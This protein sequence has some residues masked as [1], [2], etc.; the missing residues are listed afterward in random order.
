[1]SGKI[2]AKKRRIMFPIGAKLIIIISVLLLAS[3]GAVIM[4]VSMLITQEVQKTAETNNF[5]VNQKAASQAGSSFK[6]IQTAVL[7]YLEMT[8]AVSSELILDHDLDRYFFSHNI[9]AIGI[10]SEIKS[11]FILNQQFF[12]TKN[13]E[14]SEVENYL[15][16]DFPSVENQINFF[17]A[18]PIFQFSLI[19]AVFVRK[20]LES[21]ETVKVLFIPDDLSESFGAGT[22][23]SFLIN[24]SGDLLLHADNNLVLG[25]ANFSSLPIVAIMQQQGD[26]N[27]Q[28]SYNDGETEYFGAY[29]RIAGTNTAVITTISHSLVFEA[30]Q[31]ITRQNIFLTAAVLFIAIIF[32]WL[33]S[34]TI[35]SP[36]KSLAGAVLKIEEGDFSVYLK[37]QT[38]DELGVLTESFD[39]MSRALNIFGRFTNMDIALRS[40]RGEIKP[41]GH[42]K[43]ATIFFSDIRGFT[44]KSENFGMIFGD[45]ASNRIV[46]WLNEYFTKMIRCVKETGGVVD[47][48]VGDAMMAHWGAAFTA[49]TPEEDAYNG[50]KAA[51]LMR[52]AL[53]KLNTS[54]SEKDLEGSPVIRI[55][56]GINTG[57]VTA[58]QIGSDEKME[59][60]VIGTPVNLA[61]RVEALNKAFGTDILIAEDTWRLIGNEF[62]TEEML[63]VTVK[64]KE[65]PMR[66]FAVVNFKDSTSGP[67]T[68]SE[69]RE[70]L[71]IDTPDLNTMDI[72]N[73]ENKFKVQSIEPVLSKKIVSEKT[74]T[75]PAGG[76]VITMT[77]F[78][79]S[80][81]IK[82]SAGKQVPVFFSWNIS[83]SK[84]DTHVIIEV[85]KDR[86]FNSIVEERDI[87]GSTSAAIPLKDGLYWWRVYPAREG[88]REPANQIYPYGALAVDID[89]KDKVKIKQG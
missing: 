1:M 82:G 84:D 73:K 50:V 24:S 14:T 41:G 9:A 79:S 45:E 31:S 57:V 8:D 30:I 27:R 34:K 35:S 85:A 51:L 60:T 48:F 58:G 65:K 28:I 61:S 4:M 76:P 47:K 74:D 62:I 19:N 32:I 55:G 39:K 69:V 49:G 6:S 20:G 46:L 10:K 42:P 18:S 81:W 16:S 33:F 67:Q 89:E 21:N 66:V 23:T 72:Y 7:L 88:S 22:N 12:N 80:S 26:I 40:M 75:K 29:Y 87:F 64:G 70:I 78:G 71:G 38:R 86:D 13:I 17:N 44:E 15:A 68:L 5:I 53:I 11:D 52:E 2:K 63:P 25:G 59:Y 37:P 54:H 36:V 83:D 77:S 43:H 3:L 56:C